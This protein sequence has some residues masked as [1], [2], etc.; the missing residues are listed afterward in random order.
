M[1]L[2]NPLCLLCRL[3]FSNAFDFPH[4]E[5]HH[6]IHD[7]HTMRYFWRIKRFSLTYSCNPIRSN[8]QSNEHKDHGIT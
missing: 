1:T 2:K 3:I 4:G 8:E 7:L 5:Y 6:A